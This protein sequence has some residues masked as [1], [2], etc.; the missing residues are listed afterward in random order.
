MACHLI[1]YRI[2]WWRCTELCL[3]NIKRSFGSSVKKKTVSLSYASYENPEEST[4]TPILIFHGILAN[5]SQW[6]DIGKTILRVTGRRVV[7]VDLRNHGNSPHCDHK[8]V[9]QAHDVL[10]LLDKLK[11][12]QAS[13]IGHCIGG[14]IAMCVALMAVCI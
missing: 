10:K 9:D 7:A 12:T 13:L 4:K 3:K 14:R 8:Y 6:E 1:S 5:K 11:V 2:S